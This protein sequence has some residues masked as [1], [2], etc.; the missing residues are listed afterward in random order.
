MGFRLEYFCRGR[1]ISGGTHILKITPDQ[2]PAFPAL[3]AGIAEG[4]LG[5]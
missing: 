4:A 5:I 1:P 3:G 2:R